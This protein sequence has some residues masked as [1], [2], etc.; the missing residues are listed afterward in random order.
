MEFIHGF[1]Q[2]A[3]FLV[4]INNVLNLEIIITLD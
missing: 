2:K 4:S 1:L 3:V